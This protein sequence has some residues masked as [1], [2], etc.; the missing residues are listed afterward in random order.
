MPTCLLFFFFTGLFSAAFALSIIHFY[1]FFF[2]LAYLKFFLQGA[3][4]RGGESYDNYVVIA[5]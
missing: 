5:N 1:L 4:V 2:Y 3:A